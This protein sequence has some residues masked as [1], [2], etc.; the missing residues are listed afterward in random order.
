MYMNKTDDNEL[1]KKA[2]IIGSKYIRARGYGEI[3]SHDS[4]KLKVEFIYKALVQDKLIQPLA[5]DKISDPAMRKKLI[6]WISRT[7]SVKK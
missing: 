3:E 7:L 5:K 2:L 4:Q 6:L 1:L